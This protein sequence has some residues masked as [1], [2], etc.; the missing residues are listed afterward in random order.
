MTTSGTI[1]FNLRAR[2]VI[3]YALRKIGVVK[4]E[5]DPTQAQF[6]RSLTELNILLKSWQKYEQIWRVT[7]GYVNLISDTAAY[8]LTPIPY[9]IIDVHYRNADGNDLP[10]EEMTRQDYH[11][12]PDRTA[13]GSPTMWFFDRQRST[14]SLFVWPLLLDATTE[15]YRVTY[16]RRYEDLGTLNE[17]I[18]IPADYLALIGYNLGARLADEFG[19]TGDVIKRVVVR[20]EQLLTEALDDDREDFLEVMPDILQYRM[21]IV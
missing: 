19:K 10:L 17:T 15:T 3:S 9:R 12:L 16:Q 21:G 20:A 4:S 8:S 6:A 13:N 14:T 5:D 1:A 7:E 11:D 2:D 18:D